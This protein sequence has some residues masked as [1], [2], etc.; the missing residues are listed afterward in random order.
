[1]PLSNLCIY[2]RSWNSPHVLFM[3]LSISSIYWCN[4]AIVVSCYSLCRYFIICTVYVYLFLEYSLHRINSIMLIC[5]KKTLLL[6]PSSFPFWLFQFTWACQSLRVS[7]S[8]SYCLS[9]IYFLK[10]ESIHFRNY[11]GI[12]NLKNCQ[13]DLKLEL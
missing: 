9:S 5:S 4:H 11:Q 13:N 8:L 2:I 7:V 3:S 6:L 12:W 1:M 10:S